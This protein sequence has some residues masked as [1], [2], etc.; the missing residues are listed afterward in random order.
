MRG[1]QAERTG[2]VSPAVT[3]L[4]AWLI[5]ADGTVA[6]GETIK[7]LLCDPPQVD[8][9]DQIVT[10]GDVSDTTDGDGYAAITI[11]RGKKHRVMIPAMN[12]DMRITPD[13]ATLNLGTLVV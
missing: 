6:S 10:A 5:H 13:A 7:A 1:H 11:L 9:G 4:Y 2:R 8:P 12:L 3:T